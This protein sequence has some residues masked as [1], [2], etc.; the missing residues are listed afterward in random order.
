MSERHDRLDVIRNELAHIQDRLIDSDDLGIRAALKARQEE[1]R[2]EARTLALHGDILGADQ[3]RRQIERLEQQV[4][5]HYRNRLSS[6]SGPQTGMGGGMD[7]RVLHEM[8][9]AMDEAADITSLER[10]LKSLKD[11]LRM[12]G[13]SS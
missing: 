13:R 3:I 10:Q 9:R 7:P 2:S 1:L 8:N 4:A 11:R 5:A 12:M 6:S